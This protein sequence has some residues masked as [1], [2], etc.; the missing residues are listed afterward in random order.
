ML[1]YGFVGHLLVVNEVNDTNR[2]QN[3]TCECCL[4]FGGH[5]AFEVVRYSREE[6]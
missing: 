1:A 4:R 5:G 2:T 3:G 6:Q